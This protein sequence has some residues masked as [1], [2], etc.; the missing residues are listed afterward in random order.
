MRTTQYVFVIDI[1]TVSPLRVKFPLVDPS[2]KKQK[3]VHNK[4]I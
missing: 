2:L 4:E 3:I 1:T